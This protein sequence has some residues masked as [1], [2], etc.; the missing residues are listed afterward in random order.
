MHCWIAW[1]IMVKVRLEKREGEI[2]TGI[3][4]KQR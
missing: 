3:I 4:E 2:K 1:P